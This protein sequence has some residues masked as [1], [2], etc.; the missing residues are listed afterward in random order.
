MI[1]RVTADEMRKRSAQ[2]KKNR[3]RQWRASVQAEKERVNEVCRQARR[4]ARKVEYPRCI[5]HIKKIA[6]EHGKTQTTW[7]ISESAEDRG[8]IVTAKSNWL[9]KQL[10]KD[11]FTV[12]QGPFETGSTNMGDSAAPYMLDFSS[13][14]LTISW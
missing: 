3:E 7:T 12:H 8:Y 5:A 1:E 9:V 13:N 11:G 6:D 14:K 2:G 4:Q 10:R